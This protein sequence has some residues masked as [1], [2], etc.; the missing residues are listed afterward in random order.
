[1]VLSLIA[2][3]LTMIFGLAG[4]LNL[5]H[6]ELLIIATVTAAV[7]SQSLGVPLPIAILTGVAATAATAAVLD[8]VI[9]KPVYKL[10][11]EERV[12][13]G[14][15][16]TLA[17]AI[18]LHGAITTTFPLAY[19]T[20]NLS[21]PSMEMFGFSFRTAQL[22]AGIISTTIL[23]VVYQFL[24][25]TWSGR[26]IRSLTQNETGALLVGISVKRYRLLTFVIGGLLVSVA[27][28]VRSI[29]ATVA[30]ESGLEFTILGLLV[31]VVGGIRSVSGTMV[32]GLVIGAAYTFLVA[33]I[34]TYLAY[35]ALLILIM[36]ILLVRPYGILGERW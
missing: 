18:F 1:M 21:T 16:I 30:P 12:L 7:L 22:L 8:R 33:A 9:L 35:V 27:G 26:A 19:F 4:I 15:Y 34:G 10:E 32:A 6:G 13:L 17:F 11:G 31:C 36:V 14:L 25:K 3:G 24:K 5:A 20:V 29:I 28:V 2:A 23:T